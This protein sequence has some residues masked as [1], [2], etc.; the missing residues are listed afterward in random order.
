[1]GHWSQTNPPEADGF[2]QFSVGVV[3]S[4]KVSISVLWE[5]HRDPGPRVTLSPVE[6][7]LAQ[8]ASQNVV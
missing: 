2:L 7:L 5:N 4:L 8:K 3:T 6:E 1:M